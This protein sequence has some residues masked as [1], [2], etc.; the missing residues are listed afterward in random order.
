MG[1]TVVYITAGTSAARVIP[2][3]DTIRTSVGGD[4]Q[5]LTATFGERDEGIAG[6]HGERE[7]AHSSLTSA[8]GAVRA[9]TTLDAPKRIETLIGNASRLADR[10]TAGTGTL[11]LAMQRGEVM[12]RAQDRCRPGGLGARAAREQSGVVRPLPSRL[13]AAARRG[14]RARRAFH[15]SALLSVEVG[16]GRAICAGLDHRRSDDRAVQADDRPLRRHEASTVP[17][18]R[19][20]S[21]PDSDDAHQAAVALPV[22][23]FEALDPLRGRW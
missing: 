10:A 23:P 20:L 7:S 17:L 15:H 11:G 16:N 21:R 9:L 22:T 5:T 8:D 14:R 2:A 18:H 19:I 12:T 13:D 4:I 3:N 1:P 6:A